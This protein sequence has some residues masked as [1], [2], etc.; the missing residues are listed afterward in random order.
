[1]KDITT[2]YIQEQISKGKK[3]TLVIKRIGPKRDQPEKEAQEIQAAHLRHLFTLKE[4]GI[5]LVNGPLLDHPEIKGIGIY[6]SS[7]K[8]E[9]L[10][11]ASQDPAVK[12]GRLVNEAYE[13]FGIPGDT[14][15]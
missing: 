11:L 13:W 12:A 4:Q 9:I 8:Q 10:D 3:Y 6:N 14:L 2:E 7:D 5:L 15:V 1:M